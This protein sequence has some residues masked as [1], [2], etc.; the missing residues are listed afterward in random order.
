MIGAPHIGVSWDADL[1]ITIIASLILLIILYIGIKL[2]KRKF[3]KLYNYDEETQ[4]SQKED[5]IGVESMPK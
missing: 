4:D 2:T 5:K 3:N 1:G